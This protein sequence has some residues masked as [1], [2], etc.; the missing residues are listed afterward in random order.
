M[1]IRYS[2]Q[3]IKAIQG[4]DSARKQRMKV[5]IEKLPEGDT[6]QIKGRAVTTYRLRVGQ[7]RILYSFCDD[8]ALF[9]EKIA[10]RGDVYKGV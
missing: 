6:K 7:W 10:P 5:A 2:K 1:K 8:G 4:M 3:A 9:V